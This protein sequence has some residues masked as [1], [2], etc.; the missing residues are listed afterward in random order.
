MKKT[1]LSALLG[2]SFLAAPVLFPGAAVADPSDD[3]A[4][5]ELV[6]PDYPRGAE[7]RGVEGSVTI[8]YTVAADGTVTE[9]EVVQATPEGVFDRAALN[10][11]ESWRYEPA[12]SQTAHTR[13]LDF[14]LAH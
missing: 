12:A 10:A 14:R 7:R 11:V 1:I 9:A 8:R 5:V 3:R 13:D 6:A 4:A 2:A